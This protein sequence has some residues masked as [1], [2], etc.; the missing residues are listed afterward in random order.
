MNK[1]IKDNFTIFECLG[2]DVFVSFLFTQTKTIIEFIPELTILNEFNI[3]SKLIMNNGII[4]FLEDWESF[5]EIM[6]ML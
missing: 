5:S 1:K 2:I 4:K 3:S 6:L